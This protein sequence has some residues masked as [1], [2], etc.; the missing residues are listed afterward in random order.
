MH[1][2]IYL[3]LFFGGWGAFGFGFGRND[4]ERHEV[5]RMLPHVS[6]C[7]YKK[8][9]STIVKQALGWKRKTF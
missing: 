7:R 2:K 4:C 1:S 9:S 8:K 3:N 6:F 5:E